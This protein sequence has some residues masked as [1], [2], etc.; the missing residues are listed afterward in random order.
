[1]GRKL[2]SGGVLDS[3]DESYS[4]GVEI[5]C[6]ILRLYGLLPPTNTLPSG[7]SAAVEWYILGFFLGLSTTNPRV[8]RVGKEPGFLRRPNPRFHF[9]GWRRLLE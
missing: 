5:R 3:K 7:F 6:E 4:K 1:M 9:H 8:R 2:L